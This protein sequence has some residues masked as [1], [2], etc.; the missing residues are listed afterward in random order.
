MTLARCLQLRNRCDDLLC[1]DLYHM[2]T[3]GRLISLHPD[4]WTLNS[5]SVRVM[6]SHFWLKHS[7]ISICQREVVKY[8]AN[9][10]FT[11]HYTQQHPDVPGGEVCPEGAAAGTSAGPTRLQTITVLNKRCWNDGLVL[12]EHES[13]LSMFTHLM[14]SL[15]VQCLRWKLINLFQKVRRPEWQNTTGVVVESQMKHWVLLT[16]ESELL[17]KSQRRWNLSDWTRDTSNW[18]KWERKAAQRK[19]LLILHWPHVTH[20]TCFYGWSLKIHINWLR[21]CLGSIQKK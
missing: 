7:S 5:P 3:R 15:W 1:S 13:I 21:S 19:F 20:F 2:S 16:L 6:E 17:L 14:E 4:A 11:L 12:M 10:G 18:R 8:S 9:R